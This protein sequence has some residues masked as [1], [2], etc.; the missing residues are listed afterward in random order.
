MSKEIVRW[1]LEEDRGQTAA[2]VLAE[3]AFILQSLVC[4]KKVFLLGK[5]AFILI[6]FAWTNILY[7]IIISLTINC[8]MN[9]FID[10]N[11]FDCLRM[12]E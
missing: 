12:D 4:G 11:Y 5:K 10:S 3:G 7:L 2:W 6:F 9:Q 1:L 8:F